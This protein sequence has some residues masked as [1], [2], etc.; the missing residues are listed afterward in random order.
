MTYETE[1]TDGGR[2]RGIATDDTG[3]VVYVT[4]AHYCHL[5]ALRD[6]RQWAKREELLPTT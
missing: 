2:W 4:R 5:A 3:D 1:R 6:L